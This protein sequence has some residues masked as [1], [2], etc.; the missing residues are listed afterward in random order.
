MKDVSQDVDVL[1]QQVD[2]LIDGQIEQAVLATVKKW[3]RL[4]YAVNSAG[5]NFRLSQPLS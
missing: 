4:D 3:G 1:V 2:M 5:E